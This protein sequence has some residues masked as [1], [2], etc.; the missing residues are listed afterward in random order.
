MIPTLLGVAVLIFVLMRVVPGDIVE[1]RFAGES[2]SS[3]QE[4]IDAGAGPA[5]AR[6]AALAQFVDWMGGLVRL[7]FG[8]SMWTGQPIIAG[9]R[10]SGFALSL[11]LA[12]MATLVAVAARDPARR[13]RRAAAGHLDRLRGA[14]SSPSPGWPCPRS[15]SASCSSWAC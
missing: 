9:D 15:G 10:C 14:R 5:R 11:E 3:S 6:Q 1:L 8:T 2:A 4:N 13:D 7:D 12:I